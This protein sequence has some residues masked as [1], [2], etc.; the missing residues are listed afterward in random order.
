MIYYRQ[1]KEVAPQG[2]RN[3][4]KVEFDKFELEIIR[5]SLVVDVASLQVELNDELI[6]DEK[7]D[8]YQD[9]INEKERII[10]KLNILL[11]P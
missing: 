3:M 1:L 10:E 6:T 5:R 11:R 2:E 8:I 4:E 9:I 7:K